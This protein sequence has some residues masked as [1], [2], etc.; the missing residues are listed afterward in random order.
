MIVQMQTTRCINFCCH[1]TLSSRSDLACLLYTPVGESVKHTPHS[2]SPLL[3]QPGRRLLL[4]T[5]G[6]LSADVGSCWPQANN[7]S[8]S[9]NSWIKNLILNDHHKTVLLW[10]GF[11]LIAA[12]KEMKFTDR[13][14]Y[15]S[16]ENW[17]QKISD[18][19]IQ[20][21]KRCS[22]K[23]TTE[24]TIGRDVQIKDYILHRRARART[25]MQTHDLHLA[26]RE[27]GTRDRRS[28]MHNAKYGRSWDTTAL[29]L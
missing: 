10:C 23:E 14:I 15:T 27:D 20:K 2:G 6:V 26:G 21:K 25:H 9:P 16:W 19:Y 24:Q 4:Q 8:W 12:S 29:G 17:N 28:F 3:K 5:N 18:N 11:L 13:M 1:T 7:N 22:L